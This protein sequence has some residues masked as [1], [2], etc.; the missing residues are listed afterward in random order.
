MS[1]KQIKH[2]E[3]TVTTGAYSDGVLADGWLYISG[4]GSLNLQT[5]EVVRG[6]IE[7]ET[8]LTLSH[9][10]NIVESAGGKISDIIKCTV[11]LSDINEFSRFDAAYS[12][13]FS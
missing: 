7:E 5:G 3:K 6:T 2:S 10:K 13:F 1:K 11:H 9:I 4:Q 8:L 12:S